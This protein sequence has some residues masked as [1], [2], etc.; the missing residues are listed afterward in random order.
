MEDFDGEAVFSD[1]AIR[2]TWS[3]R[4]RD[5]SHV[6]AFRV[7]SNALFDILFGRN[8]ILS[9][10]VNLSTPRSELDLVLGLE[11]DLVTVSHLCG[12]RTGLTKLPRKE[13]EKMQN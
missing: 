7:I 8:L 5:I 10:E 2:A 3:S 6:N 13:R 9:G 4:G 1:S 11:G 12:P